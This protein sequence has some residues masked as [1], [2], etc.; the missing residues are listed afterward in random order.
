MTKQHIKIEMIHDIICSWCPIGYN[1]FKSALVEYESELNVDFRFLPYELNP[2]MPKEGE[3][4]EDHLKR[5]NNWNRQQFLRYRED[6]LETANRAGLDYDFSKRTH[7]WNTAKAHTLMYLAEKE[8][9]QEAMNEAL[10]TQYFGNG[11]DVNDPS[12]LVE[13]ASS[14]GLDPVTVKESLSSKVTTAEMVE[15][16]AR[17]RSFS[18][19]SV[20]TFVVND[21]EILRGSSSVEYF[22]KYV[23]GYL[24]RPVT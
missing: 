16:Y 8:G 7:Y 6:L 24:A 12:I 5:R 2:E 21:D 13:V 20:P 4:I 10:I 19:R 18:V 17:T 3:C 1:N 9:M 22:A 14:L 23:S 15:K 11:V